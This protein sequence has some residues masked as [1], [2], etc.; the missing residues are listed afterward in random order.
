M[1]LGGGEMGNAH[2]WSWLK[3]AAMSPEL[4]LDVWLGLPEDV[5]RRIEVEDG[6][7]IHCESPSPSHQAVQHNVH[8]ALRNAVRKSD[9]ETGQ[10]RRVRSELDVLFTEVPFH[11]RKPDVMVFRC[12]PDDRRYGT[13]W[14][15]KPLASDMLLAVEIVSRTTV[16]EDLRTK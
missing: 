14:R 3:Y 7:V 2:D 5:C 16:I 9:A 10:C 8:A 12:I 1:T 6:R 11:Y 15:D 4:T 13:R